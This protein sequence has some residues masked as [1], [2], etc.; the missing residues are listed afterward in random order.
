[1]LFR[2]KRLEFESV[3]T[4]GGDT[5]ES[6]LYSGERARKDDIAFAVLGD[7]DELNSFLG[8]L[9]LAVPVQMA[10]F[11]DGV[12][13]SLIQLSSIVAT[14]PRSE[15]YGALKQLT[16]DDVIRLERFQDDLM[17]T[18]VIEPRFVNPGTNEPSARADVCRTVARRA[19]RNLVSFIRDR[20]RH[21]LHV[22]QHFV[23]RLSDV[24]FVI[25]RYLEQQ[26]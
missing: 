25:A 10:P 5:G 8:L 4:R 1:M 20:G 17:K 26:A 2:K 22:A 15:S 18:T 11:I 21:D 19:E 3:T 6:T 12:Q 23:N 16:E 9:K 24:C 7:L 14:N 13:S